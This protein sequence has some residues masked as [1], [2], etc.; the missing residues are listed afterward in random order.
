MFIL[1]CFNCISSPYD[2]RIF[3]VINQ[4]SNVLLPVNMSQSWFDDPGIQ[5]LKTVTNILTGPKI[6]VGHLIVGITVLI[7]IM[8]SMIP[9]V[10]A[11][12]Q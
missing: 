6:F 4:L 3:V 10:I 11:L 7:G 9:S 8:Q 12:I 5:V 1:Y 2:K